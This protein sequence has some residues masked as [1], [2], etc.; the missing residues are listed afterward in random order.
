MQRSDQVCLLNILADSIGIIIIRSRHNVNS[1]RF[2][3]PAILPVSLKS[4]IQSRRSRAH[5]KVSDRAKL[6]V[7][8]THE[9]VEVHTK[10]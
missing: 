2:M 1:T 6:A 8:N 10:K 7:S 3:R 5:A 9:K 4:V